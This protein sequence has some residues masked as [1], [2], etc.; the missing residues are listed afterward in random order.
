MWNQVCAE[1]FSDFTLTAE[2]ENIRCFVLRNYESLPEDNPSKDVDIIVEPGKIKRAKKILKE[3][4]RKHGMEYYHYY[5]VGR[6]HCLHGISAEGRYG[7][8]ID[9]IEGY[10]SKGYEIFSFGELYSHTMRYRNFTVLEP[11]FAGVLLLIYKLFGYR[12]P[13]LKPEYRETIYEIYQSDPERYLSELARLTNSAF[14]SRLCSE[15]AEKDFDA[16]IGE[17]QEFTK[18]LKRYARRRIPLKTIGNR[19]AFFGQKFLRCGLFYRKYKKVFAVLAP[20]GT[21]KTTFLDALLR[22]IDLHYVNNPEDQRCNVF[23]FRPTVLPNLGEVGEKTGV[24]KQDTDFTNPHRRKPANPFSSLLRIS[25]YTL[26]YIIGWQKIVRKDVRFDRFTVFDRYSYDFI[27]DPLRTRLNLPKPIRKF[28]VFLTPKPKT[29]FVLHASPEVVYRRKQE[30]TLEEI[31]RQSK[32]YEELS[33]TSRR[34]VRI[35]AE[36]TPEQMANAAMQVILKRFAKKL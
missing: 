11:F 18:R 36:E 5:Q 2:K 32:A 10:L 19:I 24:M 20:D 1:I 21:G 17:A 33:K 9:L 31:E 25:Y 29:V 4:Y 3:I 30:L 15:I 16:I 6:V 13:K 7:I 28:F 22:E 27:V 14:A 8:H 26:D 35:D 12:K 23:H 34:F